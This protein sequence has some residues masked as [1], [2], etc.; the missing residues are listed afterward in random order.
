MVTQSASPERLF[1]F[2]HYGVGEDGLINYG[3]VLEMAKKFQPKLIIAGHLSLSQ[4]FG[5]Q[6]FG[7]VAKSVNASLMA[8][9]AHIAGLIVGGVHPSPFRMPT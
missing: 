8:D 4:N 7:E 5:F 1:Q 2:E 3:Q 6:K 9:I